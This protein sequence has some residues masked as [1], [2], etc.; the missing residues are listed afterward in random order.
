MFTYPVSIK[1]LWLSFAITLYS[2]DVVGL[3]VVIPIPGLIILVEGIHVYRSAPV[4]FNCTMLPLHTVSPSATCSVN[5]WRTFTVIES[6]ALQPNCVVPVTKY[7]IV[8]TGA[9]SGEA[10]PVQLSEIE[11]LQL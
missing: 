7:L 9:A 11:G 10:Q 4:A 6:I 2:V 3:A 8:S 1:Q 5:G